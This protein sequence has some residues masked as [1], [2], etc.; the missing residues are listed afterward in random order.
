MKE[1]E[2]ASTSKIAT[3]VLK[4]L[5]ISSKG[6]RKAILLKQMSIKRLEKM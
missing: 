5:G 1:V 3:I 4:K 6:K 2:K